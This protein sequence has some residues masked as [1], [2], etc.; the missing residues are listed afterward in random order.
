VKKVRCVIVEDSRVQ[1]EYLRARLNED[2]RL[3]VVGAYSRGEELLEAVG[4][5][6]PDVV[7]MDAQL[8]GL[9]G[10]ETVRKLLQLYP[11]PV[12][13]FSASASYWAPSAQEAGVLS[14]VAKGMSDTPGDE[15]VAELANQ[16]V[17]MSAVK[18]FRR[19][20]LRRPSTG[21]RRFLALGASS[22]SPQLVER[23]LA[24]LAGRDLTCFVVQ[25]LPEEGA[26]NYARWLERT[27]GWKVEVARSGQPIM[28]GKCY[29]APHGRH[30]E[31]GHF[32][33]NLTDSKRQD[34]H[35]PSA[36]RLFQSLAL[37]HPQTTVGVV[38]SGMGRDGAQ[39]LLELRQAG[40]WTMS[41]ASSCA[42][43][44][45]MPRAAEDLGA[46]CESFTDA[47]LVARLD[48]LFPKPRP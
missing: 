12:V 6:R 37:A 44:S 23:I 40:G 36:S 31:V 29:V 15:S 34:G 47:Q 18:V 39:G 24:R 17:I 38:L 13:L 20:E 7:T 2:P 45:A 41:Q 27:T 35:C 4:F 5:V 43:V 1:R 46:V 16:L 26:D 3:E 28:T 9:S 32:T 10:P 11:V 33:L 48:R 14:V 21:V 22:G 30:L 25:H 19:R 42:G 8:P